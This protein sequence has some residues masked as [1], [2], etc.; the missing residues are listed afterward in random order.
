MSWLFSQA[1]A[2]EYSEVSSLAGGQYAQLN[3][4]PTPHKFSRNDKMMESS[5]L[6]RFGLT[7]AVLTES[8]GEE[9]L[10][11]FLAGFPART[12]AQMVMAPAS[13][14]VVPDCGQKWRELSV[15]YDLHSSA[16]KIRR[17]SGE[18][19]LPW[20]SV[21]LPRWGMAASG[22]V[23]QHRTAERPMKE[24]GC[25]L[26]PTAKATIRGDC[27][28]ERLRRTPDLP[29]AI[30]MR[31]LP[32]GSQPHQD[33]QLN[34]EWV[35]WFMGWPIGWT[36][37]KPLAMDRFLEWLH[38][39]SPSSKIH[40]EVKMD[41]VYETKTPA[42]QRDLWR[43]PPAFF[44]SL[45]AE[46]CF[47]LDAAAASH[48]ALCRKF[49]TAEQNTLETPWADY[50]NVPGY[51]WLNPPYSDITPFVKKAAAESANQIGTVMLVPAD[52]SVGWFKEA[53]Q[54]ASEVRFITAGRLAFINPVTGKPVSGNNKGSILIIW[55]PYPRTHCHFAT[56]ERDELMAFGAKL[57][58]RR[59]A[60]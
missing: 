44:A 27:P 34:P 10:T 49:I 38:Q 40:S 32:D 1:L 47:Q 55:R 7:C 4:M 9:L 29:S 12:L 22:F 16:W 36:E 48:N 60:A 23:F 58:A 35:E 18:K 6:S 46:F 11:S 37:L 26:W 25:G 42:D 57:L 52:T 19:V 3:V 54:T 53:I 13:T 8:H 15:K 39:H 45:D 59:E 2:E 30:K 41:Y 24:T 17:D 20:S 51:V 43:T 21:T 31:P 5:N 33:G 50:L 14:D 28:S 56:V